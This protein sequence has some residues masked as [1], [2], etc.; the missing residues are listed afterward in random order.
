MREVLLDEQC[1]IL[2]MLRL[3]YY[4]QALFIDP[5]NKELI[6]LTKR[7]LELVQ[8]DLRRYYKDNI[9]EMI[10]KRLSL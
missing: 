1:H 7:D 9:A 5:K 4:W 3:Q 8:M 10:Q 2:S 6:K